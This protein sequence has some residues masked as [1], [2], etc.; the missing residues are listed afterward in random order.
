MT[1]NELAAAEAEIR[2]LRDLEKSRGWAVL[3]KRIDIDVRE[4]C[5]DM[6]SNALM[7]EKEIDFRRGA[8]AAARGFT[9]IVA[10]LIAHKENDVIMAQAEK[11]IAP[12]PPNATA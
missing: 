2:A 9:E 11:S 7:T 8:I 5:F 12:P 1:D 10:K 4:A 6:A 3:L